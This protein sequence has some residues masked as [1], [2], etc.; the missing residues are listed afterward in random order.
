ML[1]H[2]EQSGV[3]AEA[4][5]EQTDVHLPQVRAAAHIVQRAYNVSGFEESAGGEATVSRATVAKIAQVVG[6]HVVPCVVQDLEV[7]YEIDLEVVAA[8]ST[9]RLPRLEVRWQSGPAEPAR[10]VHDNDLVRSGCRD[11]PALQRHSVLGWEGDVFVLKVIL[12]QRV[13]D[14]RAQRGT[15]LFRD[16]L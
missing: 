11:E 9:D 3:A 4:S 14:R 15:E 7:R 13:Q 5:A 6:Q 10:M 8:R 16:H 1:R 12:G 2:R